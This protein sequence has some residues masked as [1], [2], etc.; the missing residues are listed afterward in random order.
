MKHPKCLEFKTLCGTKN[1]FFGNLQN[2][3]DLGNLNGLIG[4]T[5]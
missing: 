2:F 5:N 3:I 4:L 1:N